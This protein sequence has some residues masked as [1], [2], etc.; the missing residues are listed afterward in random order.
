MRMRSEVL[1]A[2][3]VLLLSSAVAQAGV[4]TSFTASDRSLKEGQTSEFTLDL[5]LTPEGRYS[6]AQFLGGKVTIFSGDGD[7]ETFK[8]RRGDPTQEFSA[9]FLYEDAGQYLASYSVKARYEQSH[10]ER[11]VIGK[12]YYKLDGWSDIVLCDLIYGW[13]TKTNTLQ[14]NKT[15]QLRVRVADRGVVEPPPPP[16]PTPVP[17]PIAGAGLP[18]LLALGSLLWMRQ[19]KAVPAAA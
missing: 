19:R 7:K 15:G 14:A 12:R 8:I 13:V 10:R 18:T 1:L 11:E 3:L 5:D 17:G 9:S 4:V 16:P 2:P 6:K